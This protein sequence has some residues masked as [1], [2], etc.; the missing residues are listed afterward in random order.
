MSFQDLIN[1]ADDEVFLTRLLMNLRILRR[2]R[3]C[4][5]EHEIQEMVLDNNLLN[6]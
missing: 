5:T 3:F 2:E 6:W 4:D 1:H